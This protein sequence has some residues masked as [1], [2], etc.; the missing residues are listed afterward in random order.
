M[1]KYFF[2]TLTLFLNILG[3]YFAKLSAL[4]VT[5]TDNGYIKYIFLAIVCYGFGFL[6]YIL[7]LRFIPLF[8]AQSLLILQY[9][10]MILLSLLL[11]RE[12]LSYTQGIGIGLILFGLILIIN[13]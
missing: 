2:I 4:H 12:Q 3:G 10:A 8:I 9:V 13:K 5:T 11:F 1:N 6:S 7:A